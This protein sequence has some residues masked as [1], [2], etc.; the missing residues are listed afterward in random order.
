MKKL[1]N[2]TIELLEAMISADPF[3]SITNQRWHG[4]SG[5]RISLAS[6]IR[7]GYIYH[8][9]RTVTGLPVWSI[10]DKGRQAVGQAPLPCATVF[11]AD[12]RNHFGR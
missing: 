9:P 12:S 11:V 6:C 7:H 5:R 4:F 10:T 1:S 8:D 3:G 2:T